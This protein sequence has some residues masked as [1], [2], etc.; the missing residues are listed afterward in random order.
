MPVRIDQIKIGGYYLTETNQLRLIT[1]IAQDKKGRH[2]VHYVAK[3]VT[4]ANAPF[5]QTHYDG[6]P[7]LITTF[8]KSA[9][10]RLRDEE[11]EELKNRKIIPRGQ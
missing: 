4:I 8:A 7:P 3:S 6:R 10:R 9:Y 5:Q 11:I 2:C 1:R